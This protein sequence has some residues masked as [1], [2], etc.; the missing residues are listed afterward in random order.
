MIT[1]DCPLCAG[2][3]TTDEMLTLVT[4]EGCG[5]AAEIAPDPFASLEAV[6]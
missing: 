3:A 1:I 2:Q 5:V 4:C 6:A